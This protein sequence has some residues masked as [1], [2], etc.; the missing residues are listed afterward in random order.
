MPRKKRADDEMPMMP[1]Q[2]QDVSYANQVARK[3]RETGNPHYY[4][5]KMKKIVRRDGDVGGLTSIEGYTRKIPARTETV[6]ATVRNHVPRGRDKVR[7]VNPNR[8]RGQRE[9][10]KADGG[11]RD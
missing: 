11:R 8:S 7:G 3:I 10:W 6:L 5:S 4:N 2:R 1:P 9:S